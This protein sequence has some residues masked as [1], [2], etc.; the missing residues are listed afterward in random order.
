M[1]SSKLISGLLRA[2]I[3]NGDSSSFSW[4]TLFC[5]CILMLFPSCSKVSSLRFVIGAQML[6]DPFILLS[7]KL[8]YKSLPILSRFRISIHAFLGCT[9]FETTFMTQSLSLKF[10][11]NDLS[12]S[13][14]FFT[15]SVILSHVEPVSW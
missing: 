5:K 14:N 10:V 12:T 13:N 3:R 8:L 7:V 11:S 2:V 4:T 6:T 15:L 9:A 1:H